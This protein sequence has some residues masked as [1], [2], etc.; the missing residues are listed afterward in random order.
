M[1]ALV[2]GL[3]LLLGTHSVSIV[4]AA[5]RNEMAAR[6]SAGQWKGIYAAVSL[7]GLV[8]VIYG[9]GGARVNPFVLY[10]PPWWLRPV[11]ILLMIPVFPL[12]LAAYLPGHIKSA[13]KHPMVLAVKIW[14]AAHLLSNGT[15]PDVLLFGSFLAW[16]VAERVSLKRR[17]PSQV[18]EPAESVRND[19]IVVAG[20]LLLYLLFMAW[21]HPLLI[22]VSVV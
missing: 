3:L 18:P 20:G 13:A 22:G 10:V 21:L 12:L 15:L 8:L 11:T 1:T 4:N 2:L 16:G 17:A 7:L 5:W 9:F 19:A 14:A 6:F